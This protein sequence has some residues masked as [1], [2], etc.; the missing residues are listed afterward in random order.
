[1]KNLQDRALNVITRNDPFLAAA[2]LNFAQ[3]E[4]AVE[5]QSP[6]F[7]IV[8]K[9]AGLAYANLS[10]VVHDR[11]DTHGH[12]RDQSLQCDWRSPGNL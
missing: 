1:M 12:G 9:R 2:N 5:A 10:R 8:V 3:F 4:F 7:E 6:P 11:L